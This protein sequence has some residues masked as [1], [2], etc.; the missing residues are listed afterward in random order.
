MFQVSWTT[1]AIAYER[2]GIKKV[3]AMAWERAGP[4]GDR[5]KTPLKEANLKEVD[6]IATELMRSMELGEPAYEA[7]K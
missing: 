3:A 4:R 7:V 5:K 2:A 1:V 6:G